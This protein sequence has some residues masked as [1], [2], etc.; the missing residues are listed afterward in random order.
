MGEDYREKRDETVQYS[1]VRMDSFQRAAIEGNKIKND[2]L[3]KRNER[4]LNQRKRK[5]ALELFEQ[6]RKKRQ[7]IL[8]MKNRKGQPNLNMQMNLLLQK[9][10]NK[11]LREKE[12]KRELR[13][14]EE[15]QKM[16]EELQNAYG[17][18]SGSQDHKNNDDD[19]EDHE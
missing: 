3:E 18:P 12:A 10:K 1:G 13:L 15:E 11:K 19:V 9:I 2:R 8:G 14:R 5:K 4:E 17:P 16:N 7:K 6:Q